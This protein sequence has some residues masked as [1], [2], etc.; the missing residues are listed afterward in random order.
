MWYIF[1]FLILYLLYISSPF[2]MAIYQGYCNFRSMLST[3]VKKIAS[4]F[5]S[6]FGYEASQVAN[7][8]FL[9][10]LGFRNW[11]LVK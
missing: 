6:R 9:L 4:L 5:A 7:E 3:A 11:M 8:L 1:I 2:V 10:S